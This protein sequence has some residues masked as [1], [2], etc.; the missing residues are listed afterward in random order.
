MLSICGWE[1]AHYDAAGEEDILIKSL[2]INRQV[3][4]AFAIMCSRANQF[5]LRGGLKQIES[6]RDYMEM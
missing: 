5:D 4:D 1:N 2:A 6:S 3:K